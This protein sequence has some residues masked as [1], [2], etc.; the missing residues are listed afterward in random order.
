M[1]GLLRP[2]LDVSKV[3]KKARKSQLGSCRAAH[4][5]ARVTPETH[6]EGHL[7]LANREVQKKARKKAR[8]SQVGSCRAARLAR[9]TPGAHRG[10]Q[11]LLANRENTSGAANNLARDQERCSPNNWAG[12]RDCSPK[13]GVFI[14]KMGDPGDCRSLWTAGAAGLVGDRH[15]HRSRHCVFRGAAAVWLDGAVRRTVF[16]RNRRASPAGD[17]ASDPV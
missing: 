7:L 1:G 6:R 13:P 16:G 10:D 15:Q 4:R 14:S 9:V 17:M 11:I 8:K 5:L 2:A 12:H 3:R